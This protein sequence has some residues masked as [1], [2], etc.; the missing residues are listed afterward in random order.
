MLHIIIQ[1]LTYLVILDYTAWAEMIEKGPSKGKREAP[2]AEPSTEYLPPRIEAPYATYSPV[3]LQSLGENGQNTSPYYLPNAYNSPTPTSLNFGSNFNNYGV[4]SLQ[5]FEQRGNE[6][7][8]DFSQSVSENNGAYAYGNLHNA[9]DIYGNSGLHLS[10]FNRLSGYNSFDFEGSQQR[11]PYYGNAVSASPNRF[12]EYIKGPKQSTVGSSSPPNY[13]TGVKGLGYYTQPVSDVDAAPLRNSKPVALTSP[14]LLRK[15]SSFIG[16][17]DSQST[18]RPSYFLGSS[19]VSTTSDY[20]PSLT[21]LGT[22]NQHLTSSS[23]N[24]PTETRVYLPPVTTKFSPNHQLSHY[25]SKPIS[26]SYGIPDN[27]FYTRNEPRAKVFKLPFT[28]S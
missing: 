4:E 24:S 11:N 18:F 1:I 7:G 16:E 23:Q 25:A 26:T 27:I 12:V 6:I 21:S 8:S 19:F 13:A 2:M 22:V 3:Q 17:Q 20:Q 10:E 15:P 9:A 5:S 14:N 28:H